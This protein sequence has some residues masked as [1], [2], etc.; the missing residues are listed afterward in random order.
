[1]KYYFALPYNYGDGVATNQRKAFQWFLISSRNGDD[2]T[3]YEI[4]DRYYTGEGV[5]KNKTVAQFWFE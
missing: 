3:Q 5:K 4:G 1:M 2:D